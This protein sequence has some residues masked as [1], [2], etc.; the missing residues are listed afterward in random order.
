[1]KAQHFPKCH[2]A[3]PVSPETRRA[4]FTLVELLVVIGIIA[5][6]IGVLLPVMQNARAEGRRATCLS[7]IKQLNTAFVL[8]TNENKSKSMYY[9]T[10][11]DA[12]WIDVLLP[13]YSSGNI[14][15]GHDQIRMCPNATDTAPGYGS[16]TTS[17]TFDSETGNYAWNGFLNR[18]DPNNP[19]T[20][21]AQWA[22]PTGTALDFIDPGD[23]DSAHVPVF[24]DSC[25]PDM[26]A[27][28]SNPAPPDLQ[29]GD[30]G[31]QFN[32][33]GNENMI[34]RVCIDRHN[35]GV[36]VAF[37]DSHCETVKLGD[38]WTLK[39]RGTW[40]TPSPLPQLPNK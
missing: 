10:N 37:L 27:G 1:M 15:T 33:Q 34:G 16:A 38:L 32:G 25:W 6:L 11:K 5:I 31:R 20:G 13:Y 22:N 26:W 28:P 39:W 17:W 7:N 18:I 30:L 12:Y 35:K 14:N 19:T 9:F 40:V 3:D 36:N 23:S 24:A 4:A 2:C 29:H 21:G 8:Y